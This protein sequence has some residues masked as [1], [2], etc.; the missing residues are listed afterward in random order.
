MVAELQHLVQIMASAD[1]AAA[2]TDVNPVSEATA[3]T[4][5]SRQFHLGHGGTFTPAALI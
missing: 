1:S 3:S 5:I 4:L 2:S